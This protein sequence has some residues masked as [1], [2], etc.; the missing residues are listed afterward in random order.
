MIEV[1]VSTCLIIVISLLLF[2]FLFIKPHNYWKKEGIFQEKTTYLFGEAL[3]FVLARESFSELVLRLGNKLQ[4]ARY[5]GTYLFNFP[6]LI[7]KD[8]D[9]IK[10]I[11]VRDFEHFQDHSSWL[12]ENVD[13]IW[14]N[15]LFSL[16]GD[17]WKEM[18]LFFRVMFTSSKMKFMFNLMKD[19]AENFVT[20]FEEKEDEIVEIDLKP[21]FRHFT[22]DVIATTVF[23]VRAN[24]LRRPNNTFYQMG[25]EATNSSGIRSFIYLFHFALPECIIKFFDIKVYSSRVRNFFIKLLESTM[26]AREKNGIVRPD[27]IHILMEA[28]KGVQQPAEEN[29]IDTGFSTALDSDAGTQIKSKADIT[30]T[31]ILA[32]S[33]IFFFGG[34]DTVSTL[35]RFMAY[36]LVVNPKIQ[37]RLR[38]EI[39]NTFDGCDESVSYED[40]L[41]MKYMDNVISETLRKW[42]SGIAIER[43]CTKAYTL[44]AKLPHEKDV[45][46]PKGTIVCIPTFGLHRNPEYYP[47]PE[48]F[49]P[50]RFDDTNKSNIK[51]YTYFP[52]GV[53]PRNCVGS[54]YAVVEAK[55]LFFYLLRVFEL[56]PVQRSTIPIKINRSNFHLDG[57]G[58][59]FGLRKLHT[60]FRKSSM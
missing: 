9:L 12:P 14:S 39:N 48:L 50:D 31:D 44:K 16:K 33:L 15:N 6:I 41:K 56:V 10:D 60:S 5:Y 18:R 34:F 1:F 53:G 35:M 54:R 36:E 55:V 21:A 11:T 30:N 13:P 32:Q 47:D 7:V 28:K 59:K 43:I 20:F 52:F 25:V 45:T 38:D 27:M 42:P 8:P 46:L 58:W 23:G 17:K 19:C 29:I 37:N 3:N 4:H 24:T 40:L 51:P 2:Y 57:N 26:E 49:D 22:C